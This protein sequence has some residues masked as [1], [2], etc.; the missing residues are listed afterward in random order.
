M[1]SAYLTACP[2]GC[3][4]AL[5]ET[6]I[7][8]PEGALLACSACG[9][10]LSQCNAARYQASMQEFDDPRG[11]LPNARSVARRQQLG[12]R[13]L[14]KIETL[15]APLP[16]KEIRLLDVGCSSGAFLHIAARLGFA[17][18]GV[19]PA[20]QA[21]QA[22]NSAG[23]VVHQGLLQD[24]K[25]PAQSFDAITLFEVIEHLKEP[26]ALLQECRRILKPGGIL[27]IGTANTDSWTARALGAG[28]E[29]LHIDSHGGHISFFNPQSM[30]LL[31]QRSGFVVERIETRNVRLRERDGRSALVYKAAK[32]VAE[33]LSLPARWL[34]K[35]H[36]MKV[37]LRNPK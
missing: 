10:Y 31:A 11:T 20:P 35:G 30:T 6:D 29:Y 25:L 28:W 1:N 26:L 27:L 21:A 14:E 33:A 4:A 22:A 37:F 2:V 18:E 23:L 13:W 17:A 7:V 32:L 24:I 5:Q 12:Q 8:L 16:R 34:G 19:E 3:N 9:Q 15:L 36:D